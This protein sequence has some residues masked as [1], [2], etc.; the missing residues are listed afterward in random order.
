M[1]VE[2]ESS[3]AIV[4]TE[5]CEIFAVEKNTNIFLFSKPKSCNLDLFFDYHP[6]QP[7]EE[8]PFKPKKACYRPDN[9]Q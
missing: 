2:T 1:Q 3:I 9:T 8:V 4:K 7:Y 6:K 5:S